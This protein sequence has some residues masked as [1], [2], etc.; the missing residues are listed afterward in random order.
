VASANPTPTTRT[1]PAPNNDQASD[2]PSEGSLGIVAGGGP[3][4]DYVIRQCRARGIPLYVLALKG[5]ADPEAL[6][7]VPHGWT[8]PGA[9]ARALRLLRRAGVRRL[10]MVGSVRRPSLLQFWPDL[11]MLGVM[12]RIGWRALFGGDDALI[13][14]IIPIVESKGFEVVAIEEILP[15]LIARE[16][17]YG[18][19]TPDE[20]AERDIALGI[21]TAREVGRADVGQGAVVEQ[22]TVLAREDASG[23]DAMLAGIAKRRREGPGGV[24]VKVAKPGQQ[25]KVDL[26]TIGTNTVEAVAAAGLRGIAIEAGSALVVDKERVIAAADAAGIFVVGVKVSAP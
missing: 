20:D 23:T 1:K 19:I 12:I 7:G 25:R 2:Q 5:A 13:K 17:C 18:R 11:V 8:R 24:L 3:F 14:A 16:G 26:P 9:G 6:T 10:T 4:P 22:G 15:E 21:E